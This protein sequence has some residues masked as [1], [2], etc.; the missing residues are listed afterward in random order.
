MA[1]DAARSRKLLAQ[2]RRGAWAAARSDEEARAYL[3][4]RLAVFSRSIFWSFSA[5]VVFLFAMYQAYPTI[6]PT[7]QRYIYITAAVALGQLAFVWRVLLMRRTLSMPALYHIDQ[8][9]TIGGGVMFATAAVVAYDLHASAYTCLIYESFTIFSRALLVPSSARRTAVVSALALAPL[10]AGAAMLAA[11]DNTGEIPSYAFVAGATLYTAVAVLLATIGSRIIYDLRQRVSEAMQLGQY[12]L[13]R[14]IGEGGMGAVYIAHHAMLRRPTAVKLLQPDRVGAEYLDRFER[15]VQ[16]MSQLTH[17]NTV[18]VFDYGRSPDGFLYYAMEY[19]AG[20]DLEQLVRKHGRQPTGRIVHVL[21]QVCGALQEAHERGIIHRDIKPG[22][23]I[24]CERGGVP[25]VAKVVDFGLVKE[26][27]A[28]AGGSST[29]V[30]VGTPAYVAPEAVTDPDRVGP[31]SDL[32]ALGAVAYFLVTGRRVFE[33]KTAFELCMRHVKDMPT[34]PS[35][36]GVHVPDE[37][38]AIILRCLAKRPQER[39]ASAAALADALAALPPARDWSTTDARGWWRE[40][41]AQQA[42][43]VSTD[44]P[45]LTITVDLGQR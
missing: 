40:L 16:A 6:K 3:Q 34:P 25:D 1:V 43:V 17:P 11:T 27:T 38:E 36:L 20:I 22:N 8:Y 41:R 14:K 33:G 29:Q 7:Y 44:T 5:L 39:F 23:I 42:P 10:V 32:Y 30:V 37:L 9:I 26:V 31:P 35:Q 2:A 4:A 19:L 28:S 12:T 45:T 13:G 24:L 18:A 21:G 15:E